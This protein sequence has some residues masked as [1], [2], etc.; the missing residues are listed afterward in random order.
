MLLNYYVYYYYYYYYHH[1][2]HQWLK[3]K[4]RGGGTACQVLVPCWWLRAPY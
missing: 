2:H 4:C 3:W 1:H